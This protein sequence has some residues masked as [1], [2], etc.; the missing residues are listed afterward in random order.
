MDQLLFGE[1]HSHP[2]LK[3]WPRVRQVL[4]QRQAVL[5]PRGEVPHYDPVLERA[6]RRSELRQ[7][8]GRGEPRLGKLTQANRYDQKKQQERERLVGNVVVGVR[9]QQ[10]RED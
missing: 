2:V 6:A 7:Q 3:Q 1:L 9:R 5:T 8:T 4:K 10:S